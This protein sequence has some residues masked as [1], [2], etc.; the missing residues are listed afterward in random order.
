[1]ILEAGRLKGHRNGGVSRREGYAVPSWDVREYGMSKY[2]QRAGTAQIQR[3]Q[4]I[5]CVL[6]R[7]I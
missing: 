1:M 6:I 2:V 3:Q 5:A 7:A 4:S